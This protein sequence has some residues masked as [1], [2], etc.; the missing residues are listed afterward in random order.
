MLS[1]HKTVLAA[2]LSRSKIFL[3]AEDGSGLE[4]SWSFFSVFGHGLEDESW[5]H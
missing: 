2:F 4:G 3:T 5:T 1:F